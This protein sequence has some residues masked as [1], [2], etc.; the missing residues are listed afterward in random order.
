MFTELKMK[1]YAIYL[2]SQFNLLDNMVEGSSVYH[3]LMRFINNGKGTLSDPEQ[4]LS[5]LRNDILAMSKKLK[6]G[7]IILNYEEHSKTPSRESK[8]DIIMK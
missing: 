3:A 8:I 6:P 1:K 5:I 4:E 2:L 7:F